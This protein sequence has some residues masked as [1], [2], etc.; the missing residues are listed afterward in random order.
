VALLLDELDISILKGNRGEIGVIS[1]IGGN[2]R[3]VDS[4]GISGDPVEIARECVRRT[5][6][7][8]VMSGEVD[9]VA[10]GNGVILVENGC[11]M[12]GNLSGTGCMAASVIGTYAAV[13]GNHAIA[14]AA[15]LAAFGRAG[16]RAE[17]TATGP[18]SF[19]TALLDALCTLTENDI[20]QHARMKVL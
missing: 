8:V 19:R 7:V 9:I 17:M 14:S 18:Y 3:G 2:V 10:D 11:S 15:A 6:A 5:G 4:A 12:M 16:E 13:E 20:A 1:G